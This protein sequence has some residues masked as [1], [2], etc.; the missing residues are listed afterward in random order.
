[1]QTV[2]T[3]EGPCVHIASTFCEICTLFYLLVMLNYF[4]QRGKCIYKSFKHKISKGGAAVTTWSQSLREATTNST[5]K[6]TS[7]F[8][9]SSLLGR[10]EIRYKWYQATS[11]I[12]SL[13]SFYQEMWCRW[14]KTW[15]GNADVCREADAML[16]N[17]DLKQKHVSINVKR[18]FRSRIFTFPLNLACCINVC[19]DFPLLYSNHW[20]PWRLYMQRLSH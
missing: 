2:W 12:C 8:I 17:P 14:Q 10:H 18:M 16:R 15:Q 1:M 5:G 4:K 11:Q 20:T 19:R 9:H 3:T 13:P 6:T 7:L